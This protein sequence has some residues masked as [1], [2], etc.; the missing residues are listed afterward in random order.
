MSTIYHDIYLDLHMALSLSSFS[1]LVS[2]PCLLD[3]L[4]ILFFLFSLAHGIAERERRC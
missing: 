4:L 1:T 3:E 2:D